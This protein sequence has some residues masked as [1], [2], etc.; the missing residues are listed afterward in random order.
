M[1]ASMSTLEI[2]VLIIAIAQALGVLGILAAAFYAIRVVSQIS[3]RAQPT[4]DEARRTIANVNQVAAN[5]G[6]R[7]EGIA[8]TGDTMVRDVTRKVENTTTLLQETISKPLIEI[9]SIT[10][11][12][13]KGI[14]VWS[15]LAKAK[16][17]N[18]RG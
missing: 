2:L 9:S 10:A 4:L 1:E 15:R 8:S 7:V 14:S 13:S 5:V 3:K 12:I 18:G 16:G 11:G 6:S 17:G